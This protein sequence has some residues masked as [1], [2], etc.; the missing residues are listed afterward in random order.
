VI[1][2]F[3]DQVHRGTDVDPDWMRQMIEASTP[4]LPDDPTPEQ[5][6][7]WIELSSIVDDPSFIA[8]MRAN[9]SEVWTGDFDHAAYAKTAAEAV[10]KARA[11]IEQGFEPTSDAGGVLAR[12]WLETSAPAMRREPDQAYKT[13]LRQKYQAHDPRAA[14]Y[15]ELVPILRG[16]PLKGSPNQEWTWIVDAMKHHLP[17]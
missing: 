5:C 16:Q 7:A 8:N 2:R 14:R 4:D 13:W 6:D 12:E 1:E 17:G 10:A 11:A 15:W 9:A 3:Y